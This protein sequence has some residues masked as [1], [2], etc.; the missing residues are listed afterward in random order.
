MNGTLSAQL[1]NAAGFV[2][3]MRMISHTPVNRIKLAEITL[4]TFVKPGPD[5]CCSD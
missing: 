2:M 5:H 1:L 4:L 3:M